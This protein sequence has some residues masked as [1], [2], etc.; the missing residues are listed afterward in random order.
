MTVKN[1]LPAMG[2][3]VASAFFWMM[4]SCTVKGVDSE[5]LPSGAKEMEA[6]S[7]LPGGG[8]SDDV[9]FQS[10]PHASS[11]HLFY[12][13]S[14]WEGIV[15]VFS[16]ERRAFVDSLYFPTAYG[17]EISVYVV[18]QDKK[19]I[20]NTSYASYL[21]DL[22]TKRITY[23]FGNAEEVL[24]SPNCRYVAMEMPGHATYAYDLE[25][26]RYASDRVIYRDSVVRM[27]RFSADSRLL[28]YVHNLQSPHRTELVVYDIKRSKVVEQ[29]FKYY[30][31]ESIVIFLP[32]P[33][34]SMNKV[35]FYGIPPT[36]PT[37]LLCVSDFGSTE[38]RVIGYLGSYGAFLAI[39]EDEKEL[40][41]TTPP[42]F[43]EFPSEK[44]YKIDVASE[45][46][47]GALSTAQVKHEPGRMSLSSDGKYMATASIIYQNTNICLIDMEAFVP[48]GSYEYVG[49]PGDPI[50]PTTISSGTCNK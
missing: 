23:P 12:V 10:P 35:F 11:E 24:P 47:V 26:R 19:L 37:A 5:D 34:A 15:K 1:L 50:Y 17:H 25:L 9:G 32:L 13:G 2:A 6:A 40:Y 14:A 36:S 41:V 45:Q 48:I 29:N 30:N 3:L 33:V 8:A 20:V 43:W 49:A 39:S 16:A 21:Y 27:P 18:G 42:Q 31:G 7:K 22:D 38:V 46:V 28:A 4:I 44:I